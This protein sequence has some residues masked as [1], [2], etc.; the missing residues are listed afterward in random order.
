MQYVTITEKEEE[1]KSIEN[2]QF[3]ALLRILVGRKK[4]RQA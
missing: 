1:P 3:L 4:L 2:F